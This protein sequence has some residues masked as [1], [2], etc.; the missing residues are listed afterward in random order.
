MDTKIGTDRIGIIT[1]ECSQRQV[2]SQI[3]TY[4]QLSNYLP[5]TT[6]KYKKCLRIFFALIQFLKD[7]SNIIPTFLYTQV[8]NM[9]IR[10]QVG[11]YPHPQVLQ[12]TKYYLS[13]YKNP[14]AGVAA[15]ETLKQ[16]I[17][18]P[19]SLSAELQQVRRFVHG[20]AGQY[21]RVV[22]SILLHHRQRDK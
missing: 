7:F 4:R 1:F 12:H 10:I 15:R 22:L 6:Y 2:D 11:T 9:G 14:Y 20:N 16:G 21:L 19:V 17:K 3:A 5:L 18:L 13:T 8:P